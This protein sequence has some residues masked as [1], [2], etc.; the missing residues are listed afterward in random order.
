MTRPLLPVAAAMA[1]A[2]LLTACGAED[3]IAADPT[4]TPTTYTASPLGD[5]VPLLSLG[6]AAQA[7]I[8]REAARL[9]AVCLKE[10]GFDYELPYVADEPVVD[11]ETD[12]RDWAAQYGYGLSTLTVV[13]PSEATSHRSAAEQTA[14]DQ[15]LYGTG[16]EE[17][18]Y[19]WEQEGCL[20]SAYHQA[21]QGADEVMRDERFTALFAAVESAQ[22][23]VDG[24]D[25]VL[26][27]QAEWADC[28]ADAQFPELA[29]PAAARASIQT[30]LT[31]TV[32][33][34]AL[35]TQEVA[36][37]VADLDC[38]ASTSYDHR[39][40]QELWAA[41]AVVADDFADEIAALTAG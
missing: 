16:S 35:R 20:G 10:Q 31:D 40:D 36:L 6:E 23:E 18:S 29:S 27:L 28:M 15:A 39:Y 34:T 25:A 32:D 30:Q 2:L 33:L 41:Q 4:P 13:E 14:Y 24:S 8:D 3:D 11:A 7:E 22:A 17:G 9:I 21:T 5:A 1:A 37:A 38:R 19:D 12:P 26:A